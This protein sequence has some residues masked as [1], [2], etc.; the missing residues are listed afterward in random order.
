MTLLK[1]GLLT[2]TLV[3]ISKFITFFL[4]GPQHHM[5]LVHFHHSTSNRRDYWFRSKW[6]TIHNC[7]CINICP[8][9]E[10]KLYSRAQCHCWAWV[11]YI[12][13]STFEIC[14]AKNKGDCL[15]LQHNG[16]FI[17]S[18]QFLVEICFLFFHFE[19]H[20]HNELLTLPYNRH[21]TVAKFK[22]QY[23]K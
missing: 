6:V 23:Q 13:P 9:E 3:N 16:D 12:I 21:P 7:M 14:I 22:W 4:S 17:K 1:A 11:F 10:N 20:Q 19:R 2:N 5:L 15:F 8:T 18:L